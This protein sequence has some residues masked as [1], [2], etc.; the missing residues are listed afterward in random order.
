MNGQ[1]SRVNHALQISLQDFV[2]RFLQVSIL[3]CF[4]GQVVSART[5][6]GVSKNVVDLAMALL[7]FLKQ[8]AQVSPFGHVGLHKQECRRFLWLG[9][10]RLNITADNRCP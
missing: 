2:C 5:N 4:N 6:A 1:T 8:L 3:V 9:G 10:R 7:R